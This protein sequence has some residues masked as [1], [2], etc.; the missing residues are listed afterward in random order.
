VTAH[1]S[2]RVADRVRRALAQAIQLELRDPRVGFVSLTGLR[3]SPDL[4][5]AR[6]YV[7][8]LEPGD[9]QATI[10][11]LNHAAPFL[12]RRLAREAGLRFTPEI[13]FVPDDV[14]ASGQR[15][16]VILDRLRGAEPD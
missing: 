2:E 5:H 3:L 8:V 16:D 15:L 14:Q 13:L 6:V 11:A 1:R 12:R 4:R 9:P 7:S 10:A